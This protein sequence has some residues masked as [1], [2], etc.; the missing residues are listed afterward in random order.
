VPEYQIPDRSAMPASQEPKFNDDLLLADGDRQQ[1]ACSFPTL[2]H[3]L[4]FPMLRD[5]FFRYDVQANRSKKRLRRTG[6]ATIALGVVALFGASTEP[7]I[8]QFLPVVPS[9]LAD[10]LIIL[11]AVAGLLSI[12]LSTFGVFNS[13]SKKRWLESRLMTERLRQFQFQTLVFHLPTILGCFANSEAEDKFYKARDRWFSSFKIEYVDRLPAKLEEVLDDDTE[14]QF[15]LHR[16]DAV[17]N[18]EGN[19]PVLD[20]L[21]SAYR[22]LRIKHQIQYANYKLADDNFSFP[23]KQ[24]SV[25]SGIS[26]ACILLVFVAHFAV[27]IGFLGNLLPVGS[28]TDGLALVHSVSIHVLIIWIVIIAL[29]ARTFE[30][31]LQPTREVE[32]YIAYKARLGRLLYHFDEASSLTERLRIMTEVERVVYQEMRGFLKTNHEAR[33][34]L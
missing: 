32:R 30:E 7:A 28:G 33:F 27:S 15:A 1:V 20:E 34:V 29:A 19:Q 9:A 26:L 2:I 5:L 25:L 31:G 22:L 21:F 16:N 4:D 6:L 10:T 24:V 18:V 17:E 3:V 12:I 14:E 23:R 8:E 13:A 11:P